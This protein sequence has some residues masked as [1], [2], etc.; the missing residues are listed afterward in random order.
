MENKFCKCANSLNSAKQEVDQKPRPKLIEGNYLICCET[1]TN[2][3][4]YGETKYMT[5]CDYGSLPPPIQFTHRVC[6]EYF[7]L[8]S[9]RVKKQY[10]QQAIRYFGDLLRKKSEADGR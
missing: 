8:S 1:C 10:L 2:S 5:H 7:V 9:G 3:S 6:R 4:N